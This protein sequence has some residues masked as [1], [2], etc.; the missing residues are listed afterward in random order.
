[1]TVETIIL[2]CAVAVVGSVCLVLYLMYHKLSLAID[3]LGK[4][5]TRQTDNVI[6]QIEALLA[7][8]AEVRPTHGLPPTRGWAA[9]P[10]F[11]RL[12]TKFVLESRPQSVV[13]C[14]SG[15][16]TLVLAACLKMQGHGHVF[17]LEHDPE[18]AEKTRNLIQLHGLEAW[19]TV[20]DAPLKKLSLP[21]WE[22]QWYDIAGL[23]PDVTIDMLV[24]DGPP[25]TTGHM[26]RYPALPV[27]VNGMKPGTIVLLDDADREGE[28]KSRLLWQRELPNFAVIPG[29][30]AEK[31]VLGL[32]LE[33]TVI[34]NRSALV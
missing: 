2:L 22:G 19:A 30:T 31:G 32:R 9:S 13:E 7:L 16:S 33:S 21:S 18:F 10:D 26:A 25:H 6:T 12:L 29:L 17:S 20:I 5:S 15:L 34:S 1:M 8:Y 27:M 23:P 3:R 28:Q 14:S 4:Q 24:I 11:L